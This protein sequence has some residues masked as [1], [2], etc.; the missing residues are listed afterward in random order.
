ME[1]VDRTTETE[2]VAHNAR[3]F[4]V[5]SRFGTTRDL[6]GV[7]GIMLHQMGFDRGNDLARYN[8]V[9]GHYAVTRDGT[10]GL[11]RPLNALLNDARARKS[12]HIEYLI[13]LGQ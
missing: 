7:D 12:V 8:G 11:L 4:T 5:H 6:A 13:L 1:I 9:I 10:I 3:G 2:G